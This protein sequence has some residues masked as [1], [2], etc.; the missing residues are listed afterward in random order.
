MPF[1]DNLQANGQ[2]ILR[3]TA[4]PDYYSEEGDVASFV[5]FAFHWKI[6]S[7]FSRHKNSFIRWN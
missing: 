1:A 2:T 6:Q 7:V 4:N 3:K 5:S